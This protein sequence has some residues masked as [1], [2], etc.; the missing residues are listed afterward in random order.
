MK[1]HIIIIISVQWYCDRRSRKILQYQISIINMT[2]NK[3]DSPN[4]DELTYL[5]HGHTFQRRQ[6][7][8]KEMN[9]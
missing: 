5:I 8:T 9:A 3:Y 1:P 2:K 7:K 6:Q 4:Q